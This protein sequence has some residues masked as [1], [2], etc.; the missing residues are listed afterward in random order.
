[1]S[2]TPVRHYRVTEIRLYQTLFLMIMLLMPQGCSLLD[3][4]PISIP[5]GN[6]ISID[7]IPASVVAPGSLPDGTTAEQYG[8]NGCFRIEYPNG[9][10]DILDSQGSFQ[11][12]LL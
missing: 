6:P 2:S 7:Q 12:G 1:M 9:K 3:P 11:G 4:E 5:R 8:D 10:I